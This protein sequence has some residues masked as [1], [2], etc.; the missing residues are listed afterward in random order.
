M[1]QLSDE[2]IVIGKVLEDNTLAD[3]V[4]SQLT[5][6]DFTEEPQREIFKVMRSLYDSGIDINSDIVLD[7]LDGQKAEPVY[8]VLDLSEIVSNMM[9][10]QSPVRVFIDEI[11]VASNKRKQKQAIRAIMDKLENGHDYS[12]ELESLRQNQY[13]G[14]RFRVKT[15]AD[16]IEE[17]DK[18]LSDSYGQNIP[19][20]F[21]VLDDQLT[22]GLRKGWFYIIGARSGHGKTAL[23][24]TM[25]RN[26][27][28]A[29][30]VPYYISLEMKAS[31]IAG[32]I[33]SS[34]SGL[35][36]KA[37]PTNIARYSDAVQKM[38]TWKSFIDDSARTIEE[39]ERRSRHAVKQ[40]GAD[41][42]FIDYIGLVQGK[43]GRSR[44]EEIA[45]YS[46]RLASL[47]KELDRP[48]VC[49]SQINRDADKRAWTLVDNYDFKVPTMID[50][51]D[52]S[53]LEKDADCIIMLAIAED[54][55]NGERPLMRNGQNPAIVRIEKNRKGEKGKIIKLSFNGGTTNFSEGGW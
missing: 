53:S 41:V 9:Y 20:G 4:F 33:L 10:I 11:L 30:K 2:Q 49:L 48:V 26:I 29:G 17:Y 38:K 18:N 55:E 1:I 50:L 36:E 37:I 24:S 35:S 34:E 39:I 25:F 22:G 47:S 15:M 31:D 45:D 5:A 46:R 14:D 7:R 54:P 13:A 51:A 28:H 6:D 19:T 52:S 32:R 12:D 44:I 27:V 42:I 40:L 21:P 3:E 8:S 43:A 16:V 23:A